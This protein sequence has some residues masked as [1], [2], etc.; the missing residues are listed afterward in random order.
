[1]V[2]LRKITIVTGV[3]FRD[4]DHTGCFAYAVKALRCRKCQDAITWHNFLLILSPIRWMQRNKTLLIWYP[5]KGAHKQP[6]D[7]H[8]S[9][10]CFTEASEASWSCIGWPIGPPTCTARETLQVRSTNADVLYEYFICILRNFTCL[11]VIRNCPLALGNALLISVAVPGKRKDDHILFFF[12]DSERDWLLLI[13][14]P[15]FLLHTEATDETRLAVWKVPLDESPLNLLDHLACRGASGSHCST[16]QIS[17]L[18][19][20]KWCACM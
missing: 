4:W 2:H 1:M 13:L 17:S 10:N 16:L 12:S 11:V 20:R 6:T 5:R 14:S 15:L 18:R 19:N 7:D 9:Q 8:E 3:C